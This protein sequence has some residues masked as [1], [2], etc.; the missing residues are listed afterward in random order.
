M[1]AIQPS[2][3]I[4]PQG[5]RQPSHPQFGW[6]LSVRGA[7][8]SQHPPRSRDRDADGVRHTGRASTTKTLSCKPKKQRGRFTTKNKS[9]EMNYCK[10]ILPK[11]I[12][13]ISCKRSEQAC[14]S[15]MFQSFN[16]SVQ[17]SQAPEPQPLQNEA[18]MAVK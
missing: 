7:I 6:S 4:A 10:S 16:I 17:S 8:S 1:A 9:T 15:R 12:C 11:R 5:E 3:R 18:R 13:M 14:P 2:G